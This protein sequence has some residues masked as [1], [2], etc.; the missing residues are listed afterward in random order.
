MDMAK[1]TAEWF[2][3]RKRRIIE[4]AK[5]TDDFAFAVS[6]FRA[7][8]K[9][10]PA[11]DIEL[12]AALH[13]AGVLSYARPF[14]C[15]PIFPKRLIRNQPGFRDEIHSQLVL[16]RDKLVAHSDVEFAHGRL[17]V[18][19]LELNLESGAA[20]VPNGAVVMT[21][22]IHTVRDFELA[23]AYLSHCEAAAQTALDTLH[24][25]LGEYALATIE[26]PESFA[27][28][29]A[30]GGSPAIIAKGDFSMPP[31]G[32]AVKIPDLPL[33]PN[34]LLSLP[35]L[36]LG[37]DGYV[38]RMFAATVEFGGDAKFKMPDGSD[39]EISLHRPVPV[40]AA[41]QPPA[42]PPPVKV[43]EALTLFAKGWNL[44]RAQAEKM[45]R[46]LHQSVRVYFLGVA[47]SQG[48]TPSA[49]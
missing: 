17:F 9:A 27:T 44:D 37:S 24:D 35:P 20:K 47:K 29:G 2:Y 6:C 39:F 22:N 40:P 23:K 14:S 19:M 36:T 48:A 18:Q 34:K 26:Y 10:E 28:S 42:P 13:S 49:T 3:D 12:Q 45:W 21:R 25:A 1:G 32:G 5:A 33:D 7:L 30:E 4:H 11:G 8:V 46:Q 15:N 43:P 41:P 38:Y 31:G 16:L